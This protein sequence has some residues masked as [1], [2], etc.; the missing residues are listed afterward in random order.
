MPV[1]RGA[2]FKAVKEMLA[3][4]QTPESIDA[5]WARGLQHVGFPTISSVVELQQHFG[6]FTG[7]G[8]P[9]KPHIGPID[10]ATQKHAQ[11]GW[12]TDF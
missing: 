1:P 5:A 10:A 3:A 11:T 7:T 6:K 8:P 9:P 12:V 2:D 4:G